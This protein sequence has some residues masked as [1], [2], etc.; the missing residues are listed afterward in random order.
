V[1]GGLAMLVVGCGGGDG[2]PPI[3]PSVAADPA[4]RASFVAKAG[5][6][7]ERRRLE[8]ERK[9]L[10][11]FRSKAKLYER[12][13]NLEE[14][15]GSLRR[16]EIALVLAPSLRR[17]LGAVRRLGIPKGDEDEVK[18]IFE[19]IDAAA[20]AAQEGPAGFLESGSPM[21]E[22]RDLAR[23]YGIESCAVLYDPDGI[24]QRASA[25]PGARLSPRSSKYSHSS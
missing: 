15:R 13:G 4:A 9:A 17:R 7:C 24:F 12:N 5:P 11:V 6:L 22:A 10:S 23:A 16:Q 1:L 25:K 2:Q 20:R 14:F 19:A 8:D 18:E 21:G 3:S